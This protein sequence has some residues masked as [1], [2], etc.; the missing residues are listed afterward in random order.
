MSQLRKD[1][2]DRRWVIVAEERGFRPSDF[3]AP[4]SQQS[5]EPLCPFCPGNESRTPPE[6][7]AIRPHGPANAAGWQVRVVPNKFPALDLA[8]APAQPTAAPWEQREGQ[9]IHEVV[10]ESPN[11]GMDLDDLPD[12]Q[13]CKVM[14]T[15]IARLQAL[16]EDKDHLY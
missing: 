9:G 8:P 7:F 16:Y 3:L 5:K 15:Y 10:I 4:S 2:F 1:P 6:V 13:L 11:H 14:K 12:E